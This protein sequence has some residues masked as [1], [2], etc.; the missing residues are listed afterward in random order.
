MVVD[1]I[2]DSS[3]QFCID[4]FYRPDHTY[5]FEAFRRATEDQGLWQPLSH[6][7]ILTFANLHE[8]VKESLNRF[9]WLTEQFSEPYALES[10]I[11]RI[12]ERLND[13]LD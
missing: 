5:G 13:Y 4:F 7:S 10:Y 12:K 2:E 1:S 11:R 3:G 6:Y 9:D 8:C